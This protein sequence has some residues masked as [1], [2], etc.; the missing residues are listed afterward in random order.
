MTS[1][2]GQENRPCS[3]GHLTELHCGQLKCIVGSADTTPPKSRRRSHL[4]AKKAVYTAR[5]FIN[6]ETSSLDSPSSPHRISVLCSPA[7]G[8]RREIRQGEPL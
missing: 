8:A 4:V 2:I 1:P 3:A 7:S 6:I 5:F